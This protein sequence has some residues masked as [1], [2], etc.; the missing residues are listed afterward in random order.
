MA[1]PPRCHPQEEQDLPTGGFDHNQR[2]LSWLFQITFGMENDGL[3]DGSNED[4][5][6]LNVYVPANRTRNELVP[7]AVWLHGGAF[8]FGSGS[9]CWFGPQFWMIHNIVLVTLNYRL[10]PL[11]F[12]SLGTEEVPGNAGM[13]DQVAALQW[14]QDN[15]AAFGGDPGRVFVTVISLTSSSTALSS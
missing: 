5:L 12:L 1:M 3:L 14:V 7:V 10:G 15:I 8:M 4:C 11:G 2:C 6:Y 9:A 13:L